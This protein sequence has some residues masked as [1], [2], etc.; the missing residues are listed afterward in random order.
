MHI[1]KWNA[2]IQNP[3]KNYKIQCHNNKNNYKKI[4]CSFYMED[5]YFIQSD[6]WHFLFTIILSHG[7]ELKLGR[8]FLKTILFN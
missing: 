5:I 6:I 2:L 3:S 8:P 7:K 4:L 1:V